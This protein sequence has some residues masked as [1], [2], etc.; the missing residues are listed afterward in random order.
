MIYP[1]QKRKRSTFAFGQ[2]GRKAF[3]ISISVL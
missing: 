2:N 1:E 3:F